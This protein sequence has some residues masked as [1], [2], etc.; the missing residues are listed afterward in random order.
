M[1]DPIVARY[2][3]GEWIPGLCPFRYLQRLSYQGATQDAL[4]R[5]VFR[6]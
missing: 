4:A 2:L 1:V 3:E 6:G 5:Y